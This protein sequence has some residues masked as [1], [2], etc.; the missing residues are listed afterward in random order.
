MNNLLKIK[1]PAQAEAAARKA[2]ELDASLAE[3]HASLGLIQMERLEWDLAAASLNQ[4]GPGDDVEGLSEGVGMPVGSRARCKANHVGAHPR[5]LLAGV[6]DVPP[7]VAAGQVSLREAQEIEEM[8]A[9]LSKVAA[10]ASQA[11]AKALPNWAALA[12][13][14]AIFTG[15]SALGGLAAQQFGRG[16]DAAVDALTFRRDLEEALRVYP[17]LREQ[18]PKAEIEMVYRSIRAISPATAKDPLLGGQLLS[19]VLQNRDPLSPGLPPRFNLDIAKTI[20]DISAKSRAIPG[21]VEAAL[22]ESARQGVQVGHT[23]RQTAEE[24]A[25]KGLQTA[26]ERV[27]KEQQGKLKEQ[28][29]AYRDAYGPVP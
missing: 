11:A 17:H 3:A 9:G 13:D 5:R 15:V 25:Y 24:R 18:Y 27:Y 10:T 6:D 12:R 14:A 22:S 1:T 20:T 19:S 4:R 21:D 7:D 2:L 29:Q 26:E 28:L 8:A 16:V 23:L